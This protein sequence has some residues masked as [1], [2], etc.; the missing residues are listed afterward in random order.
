MPVSYTHLFDEHEDKEEELQPR[1][2]VVVV[3]GHVDHGKTCL[4]YTSKS[5]LR[6]L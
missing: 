5:N 6:T 4:L 3:M 2:P 1:D